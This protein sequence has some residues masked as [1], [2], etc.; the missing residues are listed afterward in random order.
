MCEL[1]F[2]HVLVQ[3]VD[4]FQLLL[5]LLLVAGKQLINHGV[6][7]DSLFVLAVLHVFFH[8]MLLKLRSDGATDQL[9]Q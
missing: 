3:Y 5:L 8:L 9:D 7:F 2:G 4:V 1:F 6:L